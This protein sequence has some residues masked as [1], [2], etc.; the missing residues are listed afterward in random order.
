MSHALIAR[1]SDLRRLQDEGYTLRIVDQ[2]YLL[3]DNVPY[4]TAQGE[5]HEAILVMDL[6][7]SDDVTVRPD[8]HVA[9]W[10]GEFPHCAN[11]DKLLALLHEDTGK[12]SLS[13]SLPPVFQL[14]AKPD[15]GV[16][17][18]Y[19]YKVA[20][21]VEILSREARKLD[22]DA[23]AQQWRVTVDN[24]DDE[25]VFH[26]AD[27]ASARQNTTD[28]ARKL[29]PERVAIVGAGG[30][31]SYVLDLVAKTWVREIHVFDDDPFLQHNAF[32]SPGSFAQ[33]EI[34]GGPIKST[35]HAGRYATMR[36]G[37]IAHETGIDD[38]NVGQLDNFDTVFLCMDGHPIKAKILEVCLT[39][40]T[41]LIDVGMGLHRAGDSLA[42]TLRMT[43]ILSGHSDHA[44]HCMDMAGDNAEGEYE[45]NAQLAELK[46]AERRAR[47][48]QVEEGSR[49]LQ[50]FGT[51]AQLRVCHRRQQSD[52]LLLPRPAFMRLH[53]IT[54]EFVDT[55]PRELEHGKLYICC[56]YRAVKHLCPCG[57]GVAVNTPLHPTG[58]TLICDGVSVSLW[59]SIGNWGERCQ[60]HYWIRNSKVQWAPKWSRRR[61]IKERESRQL[62]LDRFFGSSVFSSNS[63]I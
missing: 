42:G 24:E 35:L 12:S 62:E 9:H 41:L 52:E 8:T 59:P 51:G 10:T 34:E 19:H 33:K 56:R 1:S 50:R 43:A 40:G 21:Y 48:H 55:I 61:I 45:R 4:V 30:T 53:Q 29:Q 38:I 37:I 57:C 46:R 15:G 6:T 2:G 36:H 5:V 17:R 7:L 18:N 63:R 49:R 25:N 31:G 47:G 16:Y 54:P 3:V 58:W 11:G 39:N 60:S 27:T 44:E 22:P 28:L 26:F 14:S 32:R 20:T 23:T 13:D